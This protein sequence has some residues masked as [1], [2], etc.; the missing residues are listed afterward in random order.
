MASSVPTTSK[1]PIDKL[2]FLQLSSS[3]LDKKRFMLLLSIKLERNVDSSKLSISVLMIGYVKFCEE[4]FRISS[5]LKVFG[6]SSVVFWIWMLVLSGELEN[7]EALSESE[8]LILE[9]EK[10]SESRSPCFL[11]FLY[12]VSKEFLSIWSVNFGIYSISSS[13]NW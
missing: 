10:L 3:N 13:K 7:S 1:W 4:K 11:S 8:L 2:A 9:L 5:V 6:R 12:T